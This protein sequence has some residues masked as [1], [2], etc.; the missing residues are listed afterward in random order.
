MDWFYLTFSNGRL[1]ADDGTLYSFRTFK[2]ELNAAD[3]LIENNLRA[4]IR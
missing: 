1:Y 4:S 2:S 3:W